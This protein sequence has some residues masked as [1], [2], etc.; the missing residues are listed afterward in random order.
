MRGS[1]LRF[2]NITYYIPGCLLES[3][4][5]RPVSNR[6]LRSAERPVKPLSVKTL[7]I[8]DG[9]T[10]ERLGPSTQIATLLISGYK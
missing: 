8:A 3:D 2:R 6:Q 1:V 10:V 9:R 7:M 4:G 5:F